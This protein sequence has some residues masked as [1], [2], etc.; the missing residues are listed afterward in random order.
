M[1]T[2]SCFYEHQEI[3]AVLYSII[4][5]PTTANLPSTLKMAPTLGIR[6]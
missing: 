1:A 6:G 4:C 3:R 5:E 2:C